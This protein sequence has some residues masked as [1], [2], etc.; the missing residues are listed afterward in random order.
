MSPLSEP[1]DPA[2]PKKCVTRFGRRATVVTATPP[3]RAVTNRARLTFVSHPSLLVERRFHSNPKGSG[4][5]VSFL[6]RIQ[7]ISHRHWVT[8]YLPKEVFQIIQFSKIE[9]HLFVCIEIKACSLY[10]LPC[11]RSHLGPPTSLPGI[12]VSNKPTKGTAVA[13]L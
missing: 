10:L 11:K 13:S 2:S 7:W 12:N 1:F 8:A 6:L 4:V 3:H 9:K 5:H